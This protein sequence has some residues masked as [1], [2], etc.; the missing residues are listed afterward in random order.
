MPRRFPPKRPFTESDLGNF[1]AIFPR[2]RQRSAS[3]DRAIHP[4]SDWFW[5]AVEM[6]LPAVGIVAVLL[7]ALLWRCWP[8]PERTERVLRSVALAGV[9]AF[10]LHSLVDVS[11]HRPGTLWPALFLLGLAVHNGWPTGEPR[12]LALR[13]AALPLGVVGVAWMLSSVNLVQLPTSAAQLRLKQEASLALDQKQFTNAIPAV[14]AALAIAPVDW[15]LWFFRG[16]A[17]ASSQRGTTGA[18]QDFAIAR[19]LEPDA[20]VPFQEGRAWLMREGTTNETEYWFGPEP[21]LT[22]EAW[23]A[24]L[25]ADPRT[26]SKLFEQMLQTSSYHPDVIPYLRELV[27]SDPLR[28]FAFLG[29]ATG[30]EFHE[31]LRAFLAADPELKLLT[32]EQRRALFRTWFARGDLAALEHALAARAD[33]LEAAWSVG[34]DILAKRGE[35]QAACQLAGRFV[36]KITPPNI[37]EK[38]LPTAR[39]E[40]LGRREDLVAGLVYFAALVR[41]KDLKEAGVVIDAVAGMRDVPEYVFAM[42]GDFWFK[43][44]SYDKAWRA[45]RRLAPR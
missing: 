10:I 21:R 33:W 37:P 12:P 22:I 34:G 18:L 19:W 30:P 4:E 45:W 36:T 41:E 5:G 3:S 2:Y 27:G 14:N 42:Q 38:I 25:A 23:R 32:I 7:G 26:A 39:S 40:Y 16:V 11:G 13:L 28:Q 20:K 8:F 43:T 9:L 17:R 31:T 6:G 44:G 1:S 35:F 24:A 29:Y 15:E